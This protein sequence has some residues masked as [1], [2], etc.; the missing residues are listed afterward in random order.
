M[1]EQLLKAGHEVV[2]VDYDVDVLDDL[3]IRSRGACMV[4]M[5]E[6]SNPQSVERL[7]RG[8]DDIKFDLVV[9]NA[10]ISA[11]GQFEEIPSA[12]Y[13]KLIAVNLTAPLTIASYLVRED[14]IARK[15]KIVFISSL[16]HVL[17]YPGGSVYAASK[18]ALAS[19][20][21]AVK[22]PFKKRGIGILTVFPG[23]IRTDHAE[24]HAPQ[25]AD[26][27]KRMP[28]EKLAKLILA[29]AKSSRGDYYPGVSAKLAQ[30]LGW[31][32]PGFVTRRMRKGIFEKL[33]GPQF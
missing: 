18:D 20:A 2:A 4:R 6:L 13:A 25:G 22:K 32:A 29:K 30:F 12:A 31:A 15:G 1:T 26:A 14:M 5:A 28:P 11:T 7:L 23:P 21:R 8:I 24:R 19:W 17:G 9:L 27:S 10:G 16:S 33:D 3:A